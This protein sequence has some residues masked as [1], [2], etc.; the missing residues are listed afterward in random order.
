[1]KHAR[2]ELTGEPRNRFWDW[3]QGEPAL[4]RLRHEWSPQGLSWVASSDCGHTLIAHDWPERSV[5][6]LDV[7]GLQADERL[8]EW[9]AKLGC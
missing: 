6:T 3:A 8:S 7:V 2:I 4:V 1:M 5:M 9:L